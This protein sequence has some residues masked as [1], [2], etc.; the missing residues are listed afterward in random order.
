VDGKT[1]RDYEI[2]T[3]PLTRADF[4]PALKLARPLTS[5]DHLREYREWARR[6]ER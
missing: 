4:E 1:I 5:R 3:R 2:R 6:L